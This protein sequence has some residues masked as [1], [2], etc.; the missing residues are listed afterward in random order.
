[1]LFSTKLNSLCV[2]FTSE[3]VAIISGGYDGQFVNTSYRFF[4][5]VNERGR[6]CSGMDQAYLPKGLYG[7]GMTY[8]GPTNS[9]YVCGGGNQDEWTN[10]SKQMTYPDA[11][12]THTF[13]HLISAQCLAMDYD[14]HAV[15]DDRV[16]NTSISSM[17]TPRMFF[18]MV[19]AG[20]KIYVLGGLKDEVEILH[21]IDSYDPITDTW[22]ADVGNYP[23]NR[24]TYKHCAVEIDGKIWSIGGSIDLE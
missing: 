15:W 19:T 20:N 1:M 21:S 11:C 9:L 6:R 4:D 24:P 23:G 16:Y 13:D 8:F 7:H 14:E 17:P 2:S 22:T 3:K 18:P 12:H 10:I 5:C